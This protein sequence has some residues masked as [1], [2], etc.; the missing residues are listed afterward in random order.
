MTLIL[1]AVPLK[2]RARI[3]SEE[4]LVVVDSKIHMQNNKVTSRK[5]RCTVKMSVFCLVATVFA[6]KLCEQRV[7]YG[8]SLTVDPGMT[9]AVTFFHTSTMQSLVFVLVQ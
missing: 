5:F 7:P 3:T 6:Q 8:T 1:H 4:C 9:L 2:V